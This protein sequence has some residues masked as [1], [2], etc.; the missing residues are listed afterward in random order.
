MTEAVQS[1]GYLLEQHVFPV[2]EK[3]GF[4]V[5]T[6]PVFPDPTTGK[7]RE[8]D[9][10]ALSG[11]KV[12]REGWDFLWVHLIGE[13]VNN[14]QPIVFFSSDKVTNFLFHED[15]KCSGI[16]LKFPYREKKDE[17]VSFQEFFHLDKFHHYCRGPFSTQYCSFQ[18]KKSGHNEWMAWHDEEHHGLFNTLV[19]ATEYE[20]DDFFSSWELPERNEEEPMN[21]NVL[22]PLLILKGD[23]FECH[24][25]R[26]KPIFTRK[27]HIQF[28]KSVISRQEQKTYHIDVITESFL[29]EYLQM[30]EEQHEKLK[31]SL[32][33][34]KKDVRKAIDMIVSEARKAKIKDKRKE[35]RDILEF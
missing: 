6:N 1:S 24:Q 3:A 2:I 29:K 28:R 30:L 7:S 35:F 33:R 13:C 10:S 16:P 34:K 11:I 18:K 9:F 15:L 4:Y 20:M 22:Y 5:E 21:L 27:R 23:L 17:S 31:T 14:H 25:K 26:S 8:Y 32:R 19:S 12:Y